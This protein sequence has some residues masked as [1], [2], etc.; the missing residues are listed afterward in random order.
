MNEYKGV[1]PYSDMWH[2]LLGW[3][4]AQIYSENREDG[5][6][7]IEWPNTDHDDYDDFFQEL[8]NYFEFELEWGQQ[9]ELVEELL[10]LLFP[11]IKGD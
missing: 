3:S 8:M 6:G 1:P 11:K 7:Y 4:L 2:S 5:I 10:I 9:W